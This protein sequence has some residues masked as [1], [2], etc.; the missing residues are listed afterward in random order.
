MIKLK[1]SKEFVGRNA[2][3]LGTAGLEL[4]KLLL[5][6]SNNRRRLYKMTILFLFNHAKPQLKLLLYTNSN[7]NKVLDL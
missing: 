4:E 5:D 7:S 2:L 6:Y 1:K 3:I